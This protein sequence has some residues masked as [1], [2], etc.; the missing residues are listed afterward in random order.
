MTASVGYV[1]TTR[2]LAAE[3][4]ERERA[5]AATDL[6]VQVLDR[7]YERFSPDPTVSPSAAMDKPPLSDATAEV[8]ED[9]LAFYDRLAAQSGDDG[10]YLEEIAMANRRVGD[11]RHHLGQLA[12]AQAAN[13]RALVLYAQLDGASS[14]EPHAFERA[15]T[16][17]ELG[18]VTGRLHDQA[19]AIESWQAA[20]ALLQDALD[21]G[22]ATPEYE[23]QVARARAFLAWRAGDRR[24][25]PAGPGNPFGP[26]GEPIAPPA[27]Q[28]GP[29]VGPGGP[30]DNP[31]GPPANPLGP[32][33]R[34]PERRS[35]I[36]GRAVDGSR[37]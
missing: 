32:P 20:I 34:P 35:S 21:A 5:E 12:E 18:I 17:I 23:R 3:R 37:D 28:F 8:F 26:P 2:A 1:R 29:A 36:A 22:S 31:F 4:A 11:I 19:H 33:A 16:L 13:E 24:T 7:I 15:I 27:G 14:Q 6:A 30:L 10:K 25:P 9:L